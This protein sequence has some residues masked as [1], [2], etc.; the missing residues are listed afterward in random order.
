V[1]TAGE[2]YAH[3]DKAHDKVKA[4][5][6]LCALRY[7]GLTAS[8]S[9]LHGTVRGARNAG[10]G[11]AVAIIGWLLIQIYDRLEEPTPPA[12]SQSASFSR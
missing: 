6:A 4:H 1:T 5:E 3:A 12:T 10:A 7:E 2:A 9:S 11:I 8:L